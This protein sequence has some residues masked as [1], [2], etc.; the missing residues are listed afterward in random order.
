MEKAYYI[1]NMKIKRKTTLARGI[2][3]GLV[4]YVGSFENRLHLV[5]VV[6]PLQTN[7]KI[8][9]VS[10][11]DFVV[12]YIHLECA[13]YCLLGFLRSVHLALHPAQIINQ[14]FPKGEAFY[15]KSV[16]KKRTNE[17]EIIGEKC[18][19]FARLIT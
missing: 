19:Y 18:I 2:A 9:L 17:L 3:E 7:S 16:L 12:S 6:F 14:R 15:F 5:F 11:V 8:L 1:R 10:E 4:M 13:P